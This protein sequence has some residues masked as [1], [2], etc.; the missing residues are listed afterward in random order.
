MCHHMILDENDHINSSL[1]PVIYAHTHLP[2]LSWGRFSEKIPGRALRLILE[3][4]CKD[5]RN[6]RSRSL[7]SALKVNGVLI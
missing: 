5:A 4:A 7:R 2:A 3:T 1:V 6:A